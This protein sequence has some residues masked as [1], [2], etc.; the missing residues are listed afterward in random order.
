M[1]P[2]RNRDNRAALLAV[3]WSPI[4]PRDGEGALKGLGDG[5]GREVLAT[6]VGRGAK[7]LL[8]PP[9][10]KRDGTVPARARLVEGRFSGVGR[11]EKSGKPSVGDSGM[12]SRRGVELPLVGGPQT[13]TGRPSWACI[14]R[15]LRRRLGCAAA[16]GGEEGGSSYLLENNLLALPNSCDGDPAPDRALLAILPAEFKPP[17]KPKGDLNALPL[18]GSVGDVFAVEDPERGRLTAG[19]GRYP[20]VRCSDLADD[21]IDYSSTKCPS[22][23]AR[24]MAGRCMRMYV[25]RPQPNPDVGGQIND[26]V[27]RTRR[28]QFRISRVDGRE[29]RNCAIRFS[30]G[31]EELMQ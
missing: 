20:S 5:D 2:A 16:F 17:D 1:D 22:Y 18:E 13:L 30:V 29:G 9:G 4:S 15:A 14:S 24:E 10:E 26:S 25:L 27:R 6:S 19:V 28:E 12:F 7:P 31:H 21:I 23:L 3:L 8:A 11:C